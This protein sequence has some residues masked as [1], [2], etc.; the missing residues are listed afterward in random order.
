MNAIASHRCSSRR[1]ASW[2]LLREPNHR[3]ILANRA[4]QRL[5]GERETVGRTVGEILPA[6]LSAAALKKL[7]E[8]YHS[9]NPVRLAAVRLPVEAGKIGEPRERILDLILQPIR[10]PDDMVIGI[11]VEGTDVTDRTLAERRL[12]SSLDIKTVGIIYWG[13]RFA[14][15]RVNDAFLQMTGFTRDEA[16][17]LT[18]QDLS[19][20][21]F[22]PE[23]EVA[24]HQ[25]NTL[26]E[27]V[28]Y[29]KQYFRKD[30]SRWWG[31][32]APRRVSPE[33]VVEFV[34]DVTERREAE[35]A[36]RDP[37][38]HLRLIVDSAPD[39]AVITLDRERRIISWSPGA[40]KTFGYEASDIVGE[41]VDVLFTPADWEAGAPATEAETA[42]QT[43]SA[44]NVRWHLRKDGS[45]VFINGS[46]NL[47]RGAAGDEIGFLKIGRDESDRMLAEL[48]LK[49]TEERYRLAAQATNDLIG[50]WDL[51][52]DNLRWE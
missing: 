17:G 8:A 4:F 52:T 43:G 41:L 10:D 34:L 42:R 14:L 27:A 7:D 25:V 35:E 44:P 33:E 45:S 47:L 51:A 2:P 38:Q 48:A 6:E 39:Y 36:L 19:P 24:V 31:L 1:Q 12:Q 29:E 3:I 26:G 20:K 9:G 16:I 49:E 23:S 28:P 18:W 5:F 22:W 50:D 37:E 32:F 46:C 30:G 21:E 13:A 40:A 11:F 15:T